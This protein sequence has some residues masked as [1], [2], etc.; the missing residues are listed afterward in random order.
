[1][2]LFY[3]P[4]SS[5]SRITRVVALE[6]NIEVQFIE[7]T[8]RDSVDQLL[9]YNPAAKVPTLE[10][11]DGTIMS[12]TRSIVGYFQSLRGKHLFASVDEKLA[13]QMEGVV[14]GFLD[15]VA[16]WVREVRRSKGE[17][18]PKVI[19]LEKKRAYRCLDYFEEF[20]DSEISPIRFT[21]I[22][23]ASAIE[24][25]ESRVLPHW[26][27]ERPKLQNWYEE[28]SSRATMINTKPLSP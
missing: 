18:S 20:W 3:T 26:K 12:E 11:D 2:K 22:M 4:Y 17:Q 21:S 13:I 8:V 1:M 9:R 24:L 5:Y 23:L 28:Y 25:M 10:L 27:T 15:G 19:S 6:L 7:V 14:N 16:V